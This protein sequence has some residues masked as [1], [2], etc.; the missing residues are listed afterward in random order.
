MSI[1]EILYTSWGDKQADSQD[2]KN[3]WCT[4]EEYL[5]ENC[6]DDVREKIEEFVMG[7][8]KLTE[9]QA[10]RAGVLAAFCLFVEVIKDKKNLV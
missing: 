5:Y 10:Y 6:R 4:M 8:G 9:K 2:V 1:I 7:F 3:M